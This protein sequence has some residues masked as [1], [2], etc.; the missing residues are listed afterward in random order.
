M[1]V[2]VVS[3]IIGPPEVSPLDPIVKKSHNIGRCGYKMHQI[4]A[5]MMLSEY[6]QLKLIFW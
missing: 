3:K 2:T 5:N 4:V 1:A 6:L